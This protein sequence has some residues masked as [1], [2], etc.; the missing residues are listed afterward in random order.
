MKPEDFGFSCC[1][2]EELRGGTPPENA[3][4]TRAILN[5]EK[6]HKRNAALLN[7]GAGLFL[8]D[9]AE[10]FREGVILAGELVDSG[11]ALATLQKF[12][13]V[14]NRPEEEA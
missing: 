2:K 5:G 1:D 10:S 8:N 3:A 6:G 4:I 7:A 14:S 9:K 11:K 12:I 13:E